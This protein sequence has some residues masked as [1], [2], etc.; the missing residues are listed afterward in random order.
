MLCGR[1][2]CLGLCS[3]FV[4]CFMVTLWFYFGWLLLVMLVEGLFAGCF[5]AVESVAF[6][7]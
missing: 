6:V 5:V 7:D 3:G 4:W 2:I 1:A